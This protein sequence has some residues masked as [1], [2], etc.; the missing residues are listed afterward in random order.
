MPPSFRADLRLGQAQ[1]QPSAVLSHGRR[2]AQARWEAPGEEEMEEAGEEECKE[3]GGFG[4]ANG[5]EGGVEKEP[6]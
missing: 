6:I 2:A 5:V 1:Q 3:D 4:A